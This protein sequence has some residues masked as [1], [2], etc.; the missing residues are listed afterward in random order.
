MNLRV[1]LCIC[2][3]KSGV[4]GDGGINTAPVERQFTDPTVRSPV[5]CGTENKGNKCGLLISLNF[6]VA[7]V[8]QL[9][10]FRKLLN[11]HGFGLFLG[12]LNVGYVLYGQ[13]HVRN[14]P[15]MDMHLSSQF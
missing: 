7:I 9:S 3:T 5:K 15:N 12:S 8:T 4:L 13:E 6:I 11:S 14:K 2:C 10:Q 1:R